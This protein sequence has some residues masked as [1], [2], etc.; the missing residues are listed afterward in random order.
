[1]YSRCSTKSCTSITKVCTI[2]I[3]VVC[4]NNT[5][6]NYTGITRKNSTWCICCPYSNITINSNWL[7]TIPNINLTS[8]TT[9]STGSTLIIKN[10]WRIKLNIPQK[11]CSVS[12]RII[13]YSISIWYSCISIWSALN[14]KWMST[15]I[16]SELILLS[17]CHIE[18]RI[19]FST[20]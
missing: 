1:M 14:L 17:S 4:S 2:T 13:T 15:S 6:M 12:S 5:G 16:V 7:S 11:S 10:I 19:I 20:C 8:H 3:V 18:S 9:M